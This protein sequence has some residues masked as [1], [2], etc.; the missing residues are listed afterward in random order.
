MAGE[1]R[2]TCASCAMVDPQSPQVVHYAPEL[3]CC[4]YYPDLPNFSVGRILLDESAPGRAHLEARIAAG[5]RLSPLVVAKPP[6]FETI[7]GQTR[8][9]HV[10]G[11]ASKLRCPFMTQD[12]RCG[13]WAHR[14]ATCSTY[15][16]RFDR[17]VVGRRFWTALERLLKAIE[18]ALATWCVLELDVGPDAA[19][20]LTSEPLRG[21]GISDVMDRMADESALAQHRRRWGTWLGREKDFYIECARLVAYLSRERVLQVG[22]ARVELLA[23]ALRSAHAARLKHELP[24]ALQV[25]THRVAR[26]SDDRTRWIGYSETDSLELGGDV[27]SQLLHFDGRPTSEAVASSGMAEATVRD[28]VDHQILIPASALVPMRSSTAK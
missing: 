14:E 21:L 13:I 22:G 6:L 28:L 19:L 25:G 27:H 17:G 23:E 24:D 4:T 8:Q 10:F 18:K 12:A 16:C 15:F 7:Y 3:K 20:E 5:V 1:E 11:R 2:A 26:T 9:A